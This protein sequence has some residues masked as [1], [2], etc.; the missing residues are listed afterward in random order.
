[1]KIRVPK[2]TKITGRFNDVNLGA[3]AK[4]KEKKNLQRRLKQVLFV[5]NV[6]I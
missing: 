2:N 4:Q 1:M 6:E 3:L 5:E